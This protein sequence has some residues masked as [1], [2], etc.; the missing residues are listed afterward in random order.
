M[1]GYL[2]MPANGRG[3]GGLQKDTSQL[4]SAIHYY[5]YESWFSYT[6]T[7]KEYTNNLEHLL[8]SAEMASEFF[9]RNLGLLVLG[10]KDKNS[11]TE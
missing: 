6:R 7:S 9:T 5:N 3:G 1:W 8:N 10:N 2:G 11:L 4:K